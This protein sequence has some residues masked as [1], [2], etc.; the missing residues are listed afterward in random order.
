MHQEY[1][2]LYLIICI[3]PLFFLGSARVHPT[4]G[5]LPWSVGLGLALG[6]SVATLGTYRGI[7]LTAPAP[8][9]RWA[10]TYEPVSPV[11]VVNSWVWEVIQTVGA[12]SGSLPSQWGA[13]ATA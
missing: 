13:L 1:I 9:A 8:R 4:L 6:L 3:V 11:S 7:C 2:L 10:L 12:V 5:G